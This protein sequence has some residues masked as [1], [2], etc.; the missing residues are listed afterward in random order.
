MH[1]KKK[2]DKS[3]EVKVVAVLKSTERD[4]LRCHAVLNQNEKEE[5]YECP[6]CGYIDCGDD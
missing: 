3:I 6:H 2:Q 5:C 1:F 4:C